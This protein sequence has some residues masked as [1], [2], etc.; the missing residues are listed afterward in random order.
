VDFTLKSGRANMNIIIEW[1]IKLNID[2]YW[3]NIY[4]REKL[5]NIFHIKP[6]RQ[7]VKLENSSGHGFKSFVLFLQTLSIRYLREISNSF[8][9][10]PNLSTFFSSSQVLNRMLSL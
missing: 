4:F 8:L 9:I 7:A 1:E 3:N 6:E 5:L 2:S 10:K